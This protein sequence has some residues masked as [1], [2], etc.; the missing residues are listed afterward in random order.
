MLVSAI[1]V[2]IVDN[3]AGQVET[4]KAALKHEDIEVLSVV[5]TRETAIKQMSPGLDILIL[6]PEVLKQRTLSRFIHSVQMKVPAIRVVC[7]LK[8]SPPE[9]T[10]INDIKA[11]IRGFVKASDQPEVIAR[12]VRAVHG[13]EIWAERKVLE[14]A[15]ER[16][17]LLPE[18]LQAHAPGLP[19]L[20]NREIEMLT[21]VLEGATN[22]E[23][24]DRSR[25]SER[26]VKT[27]LYRVYRKLRVNSRT[28]A[29]A[30]LSHA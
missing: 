3:D 13:G 24:A 17:I 4:L 1:R 14:K 30:L 16:P 9:E 5:S 22:R 25:I 2:M 18:T 27:H 26:T 29:I 15:I 11:G 12:A 19:P 23:I 21:L 20:T 8:E 6:N 10:A 7:A 28:K